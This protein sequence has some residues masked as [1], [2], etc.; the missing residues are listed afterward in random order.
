MANIDNTKL[1]CNDM[2]RL[3]EIM[4]SKWKA[5]LSK[6][7]YDVHIDEVGA[8]YISSKCSV[9]HGDILQM[10]IENP[11]LIFTAKYSFEG[12]LYSMADVVEITNGSYKTIRK[13][14]LYSLIY[15]QN[16]DP[17]EI[18]KPVMGEHFD[19]LIKQAEGIFRK[20]D[21]EKENPA[22]GKSIDFVDGIGLIVQD[23]DFVMH[24][25]KGW[26]GHACSSGSMYISK[27]FKKIKTTK[28]DLV[29]IKNPF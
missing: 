22:G 8:V 3:S 21:V 5:E 2:Q 12:D 7:Y 25:L 17:E 1:T 15:K 19:N 29:E 18:Y 27:C 11:D 13:E 6:N 28:V 26:E 16:K 14:P 23:D 24:I 20:I 10:S 9:P 4:N